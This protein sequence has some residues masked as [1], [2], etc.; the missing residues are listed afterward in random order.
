MESDL[1]CVAGNLGIVLARVDPEV[2][3]RADIIRD[4][5]GRR[6]DVAHRIG[7]HE[8]SAVGVAGAPLGHRANQN[9]MESDTTPTKQRA[10]I[11]AFIR[12]PLLLST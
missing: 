9:V 12:P 5:T 6:V 1:L 3:D 11:E 10:S 8:L 4:N 2:Q 7:A